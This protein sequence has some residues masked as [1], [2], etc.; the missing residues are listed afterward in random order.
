MGFVIKRLS[1]GVTLI[2]M[3]SAVLLLADWN[4][5]VPAARQ[6]PKVAILQHASQPIIDE[7]VHGMLDGLAAR[8]LVD[9]KTIAIRRF[10][11]ENDIATANTIAKAITTGEYRMVLTATTVSLQ[12]VANANTAGKTMHVFALVSDP[13]A[14]GVGLDRAHPA[15]H[16]RH[17]VGFGTMQP[18]ANTLRL[19]RKMFPGLR[20]VGVVWNPAEANSEANTKLGR[21]VCGELGIDLLEATVDSTSGVK[22]AA[23]SL[24]ARGAQALWVSGDVT[25]LTAL[26]SVVAAARAAR[27]PVFTSIPGSAE[28]GALFDIGADYHEVGR[29]AGDLAARLLQGT[30]P[31]SIPIENVMPEKL[32]IN[33][34]ALAGLKDPWRVPADVLRSAQLVGE[35]PR[36]AAPPTAP[37][38]AALR[39][40]PGRTFTIGLV[41]F[42]PEPGAEICMQG[43]FDGL[44]DLGYVEGSNLEV[45]RAHAQGEIANI[46][47]LLQNY[48]NQDLD[49]IVTLTTPCL[50]AACG[51][52]RHTPVVFTYVYD[53]IAA[54]A[55]SSLTAHLP[56]VTGVGSFPP[57]DE[58]VAMIQRLV[59]AAR[60]VGTL[61]NSSEANSRKVIE[62]ARTAFAQRGLHLEEVTVTNASEVFQAAQALVARKVDALWITGDNTAIQGFD[63]IVKVANDAHLPII[64]NDP[65]ITARGAL[66]CVGIG[67]YYSGYAA[68]TLAARVLRGASPR[69]LPMENLVRKTVSLNLDAARRLGIAIPDAILS[70]ADEVIDSTGTRRKAA[71]PPRP[72]PPAGAAPA[73][74]APLAKTWKVDILEYVNVAD[75]EDAER[76]MRAGLQASGLVEGRDYVIRLRNAQ[77]DMPTLSALV[78]AAQSAG[79]DLLMT[80][81]TPTLQAALQR[82]RGVPIVFTFVANAV[83]AGAG[84]SNE[85]HLP[86]VTGIPTRSAYEQLIASVRE[87]LP[88][89]HRIGTLFVPAEVNS[90]FNK[91]QL[92]TAARAAGLELVATPVNTSTEISDA[93][94]ALCNQNLDAVTQV[95]GNLTTAA[96]ASITQAAQRARIPVFG[97]LSGNARDGA[98][99]VVARDY[100]DGGREAGLMAARIMRGERPATIPFQPLTKTKVIVNLDAARAAGLT[101]PPAFRQR[102][103]EVIGQ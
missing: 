4:R 84:R 67:F 42:A 35:E 90:V 72:T 13:F 28:R 24:I 68:A 99:V 46:P 15:Q 16:P 98:A 12:A 49:L 92:A 103:D 7:G 52:V 51:T 95:A 53:P 36:A 64:N 19:A 33:R 38:A 39:P 73:A 100:F 41:Y 48:D 9:G 65:E 78:D 31:M 63:A 50:T 27:I 14:A 3:A 66:A 71:A 69:D 87:L 40:P 61:Y 76:G 85:D 32:L 45:R 89:A 58:T 74:A 62:V 56:Y 88:N 94:L 44:R 82:A 22:E 18:V 34:A 57:V 75:S 17:L 54:G 59:P 30:D 86:N 70:E 1:L 60:T 6:L 81:S 29:L 47:A 83:V 5:R 91:D 101:I 21:T 55:G 102:A 80:L 20:S 23:N 26:D 77:G 8:G 79:T 93:A 43:L 37:R 96:F 10:N 11:A 97:S 2:A 25:V